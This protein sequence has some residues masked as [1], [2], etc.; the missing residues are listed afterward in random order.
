MREVPLDFAQIQLTTRR[1]R[2]RPLRTSDAE[3]MFAVYSDPKVMR[4]GST[5][6]WSSVETAHTSLARTDTGMKDRQFLRLALTLGDADRFIGDCC[7]FKFDE[8]CRH[9]EVGYS[10]DTNYWGQGYMHEAL[11]ALLNYGFDH[12]HLN[13]VEADVDPRNTASMACLER[14]GFVKEGYLRERWI[15][16]GVLSDTALFGLLRREWKYAPK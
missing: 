15:V 6:V 10:M 7:L 14:L 3:N 1:L 9:A 12:L 4:Y 8:Q 5:P 2:L 16:D 13:R 11:I